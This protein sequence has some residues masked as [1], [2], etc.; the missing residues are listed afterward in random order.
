MNLSGP[1]QRLATRG[2]GLQ[3][4]A[5]LAVVFRS[6]PSIVNATLPANGTMRRVEAQAHRRGKRREEAPAWHASVW[7]EVRE[8]TDGA[9]SRR[10]KILI[11]DEAQLEPE[12]VAWG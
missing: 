8:T 11:T 10:I 7:D 1:H 2:P 9:L 6:R 12:E 4:A 5:T 3:G